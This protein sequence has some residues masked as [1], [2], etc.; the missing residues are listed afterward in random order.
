[1]RIFQEDRGFC[2]PTDSGEEMFVDVGVY[3][4]PGSGS[5]RPGKT[6]FVAATA[7]RAVE[8]F[9]RDVEGYQMLYV[10]PPPLFAMPAL[11]LENDG[12]STRVAVQAHHNLVKHTWS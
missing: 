10:A 11:T 2:K 12:D 6:G 9:V 4:V 5:G 8:K 3:G 1:M 7:C